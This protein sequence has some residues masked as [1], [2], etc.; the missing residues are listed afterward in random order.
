M[1]LPL[2]LTCAA[3]FLAACQTTTQTAETETSVGMQLATQ[4]DM[5]SVVGKTLT[6]GP[7]Q[8]FTIG[9]DGSLMGTWDGN[10]LVGTYVMRDGYFCRTLSQGPRGP[11]P[12]DCQLLI[13]NGS[14]LAVT[15]DRGAGS[16]FTYT[17]S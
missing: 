3:I 2:A 5:S 17:V 6:L 14:N 15:R 1:K 8:S 12:E 13:L 10:P 11:S 16:A 7:G 4:S 9:A